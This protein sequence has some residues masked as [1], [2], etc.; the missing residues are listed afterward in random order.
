MKVKILLLPRAVAL[1]FLTLLFVPFVAL[2]QTR[3]VTGTVTDAATKTPLK[4]ASVSTDKST[5]TST[6]ENGRFSLQVPLNGRITISFTGFAS[7]TIE[8]PASGELTIQLAMT[9][10][11]MDEV[12]VIGYGQVK[13]KD[14]TGSI[15]QIRPDKIA[16]QNP[17]TTQDILRGTPGVTVGF[18]AAA[19]SAK[20]LRSLK[21]SQ[22]PT[23]PS[24]S[25]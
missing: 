1:L 9:D 4:G 18:D 20:C 5:G 24:S 2:A 17:N 8:V 12:V 6:D 25:A 23:W 13:K 15:V 22:A 19:A 11:S 3:V 16:D 21:S 14:L 10:K 7:Q